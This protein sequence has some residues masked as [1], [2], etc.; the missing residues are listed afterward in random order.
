MMDNEMQQALLPTYMKKFSCIGSECEDTCCNGWTISIDKNTFKKYKKL[1]NQE[2]KVEIDKSLKRNKKNST[3]AHYA[4]FRLK[5]H[6]CPLQ[7]EE[8]WCKI[9]RDLG[10]S[11]LSNT[12]SIYP[13]KYNA[14]DNIVEMGGAL[15][16]PEIT[17]HAL[18]NP[19]GI[20]F[21]MTLQED[22]SRGTRNFIINSQD[23]KDKLFWEIRSFAIFLLQD[24]RFNVEERLINLGMW[25]NKLTEIIQTNDEKKLLENINFFKQTLNNNFVVKSS[26]AKIKPNYDLYTKICY[27][28]LLVRKLFTI[29]NKRYL[30]LLDDIA[31][32]LKM[33]GNNVVDNFDELIVGIKNELYSPF[34]K[35]K[36]YIL[37]NYL[38][39]DLFINCF[40]NSKDNLFEQYIL[41]VLKFALVK[42]HLYGVAAKYKGLN[43]ERIV[44]VIQT[45]SKC[46]E[47]NSGYLKSIV[48]TVKLNELDS[49]AH[50]AILIKG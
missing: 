2:I 36:E 8:G 49:L 30:D 27:E 37:E 33:D 40:G 14:I 25:I 18:F 45:F 3:D 50:M 44:H 19:D 6:G 16:C 5:S 22:V 21:E 39:N 28:I 24:R 10:E 41:V 42:L 47:H 34:F 20:D 13:R 38:V 15:S 7:S 29:D 23:V 31:D 32:G 12:C 26:I 9:H 17:R 35:E 48:D 4:E 43:D 46:I 1:R 11:Y